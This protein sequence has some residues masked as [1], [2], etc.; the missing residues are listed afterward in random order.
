MP[1]FNKCSAAWLFMATKV[2]AFGTLHLLIWQL[3]DGALDN[4][5]KYFMST[6]NPYA[7]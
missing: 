2:F 7:K 3:V 1:S 6:V 4:T 5:L